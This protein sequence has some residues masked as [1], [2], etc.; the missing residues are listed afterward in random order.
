MTTHQF[1]TLGNGSQTYELTEP[2]RQ[3][4][5]G[6][7]VAMMRQSHNGELVTGGWH[8][9]VAN[10]MSEPNEINWSMTDF[11]RSSTVILTPPPD[12]PPDHTPV[13]E[14]DT[15]TIVAGC[16]LLLILMHLLRTK[17]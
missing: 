10:T 12:R 11:E 1:P 5:N 4:E 6:Y 14:P 8:I 13:P 16:F 7:F 15:L 3:I 2:L 17:K 9:P